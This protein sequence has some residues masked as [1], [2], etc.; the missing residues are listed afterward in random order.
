M[1]FQDVDAPT[2]RGDELGL[3]GDRPFQESRLSPST[4]R[5][6][7]PGPLPSP[8]KVPRRL[9]AVQQIFNK[10]SLNHVEPYGNG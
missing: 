7:L 6:G 10:R 2:K 5:R 9:F 4:A 8:R 1:G 3:G